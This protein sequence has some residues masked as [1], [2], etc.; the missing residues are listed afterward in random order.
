MK[1]QPLVSVIMPAY[2]HEDYVGAAIE[3]VLNQSYP[4]IE[5]LIADDMSPDTTEQIIGDYAE[6]YPEKIKFLRGDTNKGTAYR[7]T[8]LVQ[9]SKGDF[10]IATASD[11]LLPKNAVELKLNFLL[12]NPDVD[13]VSTDF[14]LLLANDQIITGQEKLNHVPQFSKY[15]M[16]DFQNLYNELLPG[17]FIPG[18]ALCIRVSRIPRSEL[19]QDTHSPNVSDYELWMRLALDYTW[20][21]IPESTWVYRWHDSNYSSPTNPNNTQQ[22]VLSQYVYI[23]SKQL[24]RNTSILQKQQVCNIIIH[25][26]NLLNQLVEREKTVL[27]AFSGES[28]SMVS[29]IIPVFNKVDFT[30]KCIASIL[31]NTDYPV[32]EIII[33]DNGSSD[34]TSGYLKEISRQHKH[35]RVITNR[36]NLGFAKANNRGVSNARGEYIL[37]LNND[38][39][40]FED[41][42]A[43]MVKILQSDPSVG[44]VGSKLLF[45]DGRI[46]HAG[47]VLCDDSLVGGDPLVARHLYYQNDANFA[48]ANELRSYQVLTAACLLIRKEIYDDLRGYD[49]KFWNG[50][51][52]IDLCLRIRENGFKLIY[53]PASVLIHHESQSGPERFS[54]VAENMKY[55]HKKWL[56]KLDIDMVMGADYKSTLG[57]NHQ[58]R[59][60][61]IPAT[62]EE[63]EADKKP[64]VSIVMLTYN[65]LKYTKKCIRSI[66]KHT[67]C[68]HEVIFVDNGSKDGT[69]AYLGQLAKDHP[70]YHFI[71]NEKNK[72]FAAGNNQGV[73]AARGEYV[74]LLNND[75]LVSDGWLGQLVRSLEKD[76]G[77]GMVGPITNFIS[78]RQMIKDVSYENDNEFYEFAR[79]VRENNKGRITPRRRIAGFAVLMRKAL[80]EEIG[81]LDESFGIGNY[82]DDDLC[83]RIREAGYVIMVDESVFIHHYG[84]RTFKANKINYRQSLKVKGKQFRKKWPNV[85]YNEL[86]ELKNPL[87]ELHDQWLK[88]GVAYLDL[89]RL[90]EAMIQFYRIIKDNPISQDA[91]FGLGVCARKQN[92][93][94][95]ALAYLNKLLDINPDH[96]NAYNQ[97]GLI[98]SETGD[99]E[100]ART[101]FTEAVEKDPGF[102]D[103]QR[104]LAE[105]L[106]LMEEYDSAVQAYVTIL[107]N[108]PD[109][110]SSLL[111]MAQ[112]NEE[113]GQSRDAI[114]WAEKVL[115]LVPDHSGAKNILSAAG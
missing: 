11:D 86:L 7:W 107:D 88:E 38:T 33:V 78:G 97:S 95:A 66:Q 35:I 109:D 8:E 82:E 56:N 96:A 25:H 90:E 29:I 1:E 53:Q 47:V 72:G 36:D 20:E 42:M 32:Y 113:A 14:D 17:N 106:L 114:K 108:H 46:Q 91:L 44:A 80:Y 43:P 69:R 23:L 75:V 37:C 24:L 83:I 19:Y 73:K 110:V 103:A 52:D 12:E 6:K 87:K 65:A 60:Y 62:V 39:E 89:D 4:N 63:I 50:Y 31:Q 77:I 13:V 51:E 9:M 5:L 3:S 30:R 70:E 58:I 68:P 41:W 61:Q 49:E 15:Y 21:Y 93:H 28:T 45:P 40:A 10:I 101:L 85:D 115:T 64:L 22:T 48:E 67:H 27:A 18:G 84:S 112:L 34:G 98:A 59:P 105:C 79:L 2:N 81:G 54:K 99:L 71:L 16:I 111:R 92:K 74:M 104:N 57:E 94:E 100:G 55:L 26:V 76:E 102:L